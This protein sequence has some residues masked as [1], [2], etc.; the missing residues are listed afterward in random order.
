VYPLPTAL[1]QG[2]QKVT[3]RIQSAGT[4]AGGVFGVRVMKVAENP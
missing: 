4:W 3:L 1:I 2:K